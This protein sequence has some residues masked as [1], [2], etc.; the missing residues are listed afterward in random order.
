M[1]GIGSKDRVEYEVVEV[2][3]LRRTVMIEID[4]VFYG[5][6][7]PDVTNLLKEYNTESDLARMSMC[8]MS[9][10]SVL[11]TATPTT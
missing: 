1:F 7:R 9:T 10:C 5:I 2:G 8:K 11:T 4:I 3:M 6:V